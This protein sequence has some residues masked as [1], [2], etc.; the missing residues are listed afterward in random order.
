MDTVAPI[1][2]QLFSVVRPFLVKS[3]LHSIE[4]Y[5]IIHLPSVCCGVQ[6]PSVNHFHMQVEAVFPLSISLCLLFKAKFQLCNKPHIFNRDH[7][8]RLFFTRY[9]D[10]NIC[11]SEYKPGTT[12][13]ICIIVP[14]CPR[15]S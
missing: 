13:P 5:C 10:E 2:Y 1:K 8:G 14:I 15:Q 9:F 4:L 3:S 7:T 11:E 6:M 12:C